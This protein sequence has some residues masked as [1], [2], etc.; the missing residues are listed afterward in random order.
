M[1][2]IQEMPTHLI[3]QDSF[4]GQPIRILKNKATNE[5]LL[6]IEYVARVL[7]FKDSIELMSS[8]EAL[9]IVNKHWKQTGNF[10]IKKY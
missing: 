5:I 10:P 6:N 2:I 9:D 1:K 4:N 3:Y 7:G 8:N